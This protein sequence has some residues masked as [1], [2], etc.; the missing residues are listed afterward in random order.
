[1]PQMALQSSWFRQTRVVDRNPLGG[2]ANHLDVPDNGVLQLFRRK[3]RLS[4]WLNKARD[5][6]A[7]L[8]HVVQVEPVILH[9]GVASRR[10]RSRTYQ[11]SDF[12]GPDMDLHSEQL[13]E[14]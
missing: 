14:I 8:Q 7:A 10:I 1:M 11:W 2:L 6:L 5:S 3:E 12:L 13:L 4:A 9:S